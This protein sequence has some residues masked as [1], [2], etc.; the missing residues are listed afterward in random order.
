[1]NYEFTFNYPNYFG[2]DDGEG[3]RRA[4]MTT[5]KTTEYFEA[6]S[7]DEA[8]LKVM[9]IMRERS[10]RYPNAPPAEAISLYRI[11]DISMLHQASVA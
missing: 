8:L 10:Q 4:R 11:V 3:T 2:G 1:M 5:D 9:K 6:E 7:D